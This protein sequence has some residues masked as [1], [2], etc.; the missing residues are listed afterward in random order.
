MRTI[1]SLPPRFQFTPLR[2]GRRLIWNLLCGFPHFNSRPS[3]RG[4]AAR[5]TQL[6]CEFFISIHA[7]PRGATREAALML[8]NSFIS[9]H[10]PPRGATS[11]SCEPMRSA[12]FQF[13]PLREGRQ[14][15]NAR[16]AV[17]RLISIH[18]P[19]RGATGSSSPLVFLF[20]FQFTPLR[21][22]RLICAID[23]PY[24]VLYFNSRPSA[25]GDFPFSWP[26]SAFRI[27][28]HAPP[29]GATALYGY[30]VFYQ[31]FQ[32]TPLREGRLASATCRMRSVYFNSRPSARGDA[33][34][35]PRTAGR[36]Q[37]QFTPLRE[38]RP[39]DALA[40]R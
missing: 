35:Q 9:I 25:R 6:Y 38:G 39:A 37:F 1:C 5:C 34:R 13:T 16:D 3:A 40:L 21:E 33:Q 36:G 30:N 12:E 11:S 29:R 31:P 14:V 15:K 2:E 20:P 7:P 23:K 28:I 18:A 22:G 26:F 10:A 17:A 8:A 32:F 4:D 24:R 19:P 27:S